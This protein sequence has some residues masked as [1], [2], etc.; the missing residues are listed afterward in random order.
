[1][2]SYSFYNPP[3]PNWKI[4]FGD[5]SNFCISFHVEKSPNKFQRWMMKKVLGINWEKL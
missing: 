3:Q 5:N 1:M 4:T 2:E